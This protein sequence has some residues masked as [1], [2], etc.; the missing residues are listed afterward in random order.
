MKKPDSLFVQL[1]L[2]AWLLLCWG[3]SCIS[4]LLKQLFKFALQACQE[5]RYR[6]TLFYKIDKAE[7]KLTKTLL[8]LNNQEECLREDKRRL[9]QQFEKISCPSQYAERK[10]FNRITFIEEALTIC[11][12]ECNKRQKELRRVQDEREEVRLLDLMK[13]KSSPRKEEELIVLEENGASLPL[14]DEAEL[15]N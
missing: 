2:L 6:Q 5:L 3:I 8:R 12:D 14:Y 13:T 4:R 9:E 15:I 10:F 1:V 7:D 11:T